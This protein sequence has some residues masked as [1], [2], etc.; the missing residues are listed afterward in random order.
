MEVWSYSFYRMALDKRMERGGVL[1]LCGT[2]HLVT[3]QEHL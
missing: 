3:L 2:L 1:R